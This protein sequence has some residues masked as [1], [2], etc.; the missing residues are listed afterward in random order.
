MVI[1]VPLVAVLTFCWEV[2]TAHMTWCSLEPQA[3]LQSDVALLEPYI[4]RF[5]LH[6]LL[7]ANLALE[8]LLWF[9]GSV[10]LY[11]YCTSYTSLYD[12][13]RMM[14]VLVAV[15]ARNSGRLR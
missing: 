12:I 2:S 13:T 4:L 11:Y 10:E 7:L 9:E 15:H 5:L 8:Q 6:L 1:E 3:P 14:R